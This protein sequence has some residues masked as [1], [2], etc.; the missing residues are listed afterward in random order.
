MASRSAGTDD[1]PLAELFGLERDEAPARCAREAEPF[2]I[3][4]QEHLAVEQSVIV[5]LT[6]SNHVTKL[7]RAAGLHADSPSGFKDEH[8][9][10]RR[11][12][13]VLRREARADSKNL[14]AGS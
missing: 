9:P 4:H 13:I 3:A 1:D 10:R 7:A 2:A 5:I 8:P 12:L 14:R 6:G 11:D